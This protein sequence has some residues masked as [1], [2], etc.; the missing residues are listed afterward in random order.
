MKFL[1][2]IKS[3][4]QKYQEGSKVVGLFG[5]RDVTVYKPNN[6]EGIENLYPLPDMKTLPEPFA[7][8]AVGRP[9]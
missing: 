8:G 2:V 3:R 6:D 5:W 7:I 1:S 4:C 9:G